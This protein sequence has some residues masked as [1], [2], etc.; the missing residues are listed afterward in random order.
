MDV[1]DGLIVDGTRI[2]QY[3]GIDYPNNAAQNFR[4]N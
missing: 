4:L 3:D 2:Q 1:T